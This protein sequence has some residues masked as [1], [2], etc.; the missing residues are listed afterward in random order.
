MKRTLIITTLIVGLMTA[1][2]Y[3]QMGQGHMTERGMMGS[4]SEKQN[5]ENTEDRDYYPCHTEKGMMGH[6]GYGM[7]G[8]GHMG[9][10]MGTGH[11]GGYGMKDYKPEARQKFMDETKDLRRQLHNK[12]FEYFEA[13]RKPEPDRETVT[14]LEKEIRDLQWD[15]YEKAPK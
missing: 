1:Y 14:K 13:M 4:Q 3:A 2:G 5:A 6:S 15:I 9:G 11:M 7:M 8:M 10:M 12:K